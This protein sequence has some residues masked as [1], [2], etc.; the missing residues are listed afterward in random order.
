MNNMKSLKPIRCLRRAGVLIC[1]VTALIALLSPRVLAW[2]PQGHSIIGEAAVRALPAE[3]PAFFRKGGAFVAHCAQ[4]P[5]LHKNRGTPLIS[6][7]ES[8]EHYIDL[9]FLGGR[10]L[11]PTR[12]KYLQLL[13]QLKLDGGYTGYL[14]Y[15]VGEWTERLAIT[16]AEYRKYPDNPYIQSKC[17]VY[18]GFLAHYA[19]DMCM[20]LHNTRDHDGRANPDGTSPHTGIHIK[21]DSLIEKLNLRPAD[22]AKDQKI[23]PLNEL[24]PGI[25]REMNT[26]R[27]LIDR[28]YELEPL[29]PPTDNTPQSQAWKPAPEITAFTTE[30]AREATRFLAS[31][32][33]TAWQQSARVKLP[34][35][36]QREPATLPVA[37]TVTSSSTTKLPAAGAK[38]QTPTA[39]APAK[40]PA[41]KTSPMR[42][43]P[44]GQKVK[45]ST[46]KPL[47]T[48]PVS[49]KR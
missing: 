26:S 22:L 6:D 3:M 39:K 36:L 24:L 43:A 33:V 14:P 31:L 20:P 37:A 7:R 32:Y 12:D 16:F 17:L 25:I 18:A 13:A 40:A 29:L 46:T 19:G 9:E 35:W 4:D 38:T 11:P 15:A 8:P 23:E 47:P 27:T 45:P 2:W 21:V 1:A 34:A 44:A 42:V 30:R 5:D 49:A 48:R 28:T 10:A 41:V